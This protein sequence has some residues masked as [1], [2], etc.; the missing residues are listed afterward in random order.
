MY[1]AHFSENRF[2]LSDCL[3]GL[4]RDCKKEKKEKHIM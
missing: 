1:H 2:V 4:M 3:K